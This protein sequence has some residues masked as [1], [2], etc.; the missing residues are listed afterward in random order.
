MG[1]LLLIQERRSRGLMTPRHRVRSD[2]RGRQGHLLLDR[3]SSR[4]YMDRVI[5]AET[6]GFASTKHGA[7][8]GSSPLNLLIFVRCA[9]AD[10]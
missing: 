7:R 10:G 6:L 8:S 1:L 9:Q 3:H 5:V 2:S 4:K